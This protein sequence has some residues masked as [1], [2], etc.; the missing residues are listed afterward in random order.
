LLGDAWYDLGMTKICSR[1]IAIAALLGGSL[2]AAQ[3]VTEF[4]RPGDV[5]RFEIK[6]SGPDAVK[7]KAVSLQLNAKVGPPDDQS[8]FTTAFTSMKS[9]GPSAPNTFEAEV[10]VPENIASG[11]YVLYINAQAETGA[12]RYESGQQFQLPLLHVRNDRTFKAPQVTVV[13]RR[14]P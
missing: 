10:A 7:V 14:A 13:E 5:V 11:D 6:F 12:A 2:L 1:T 3:E 9:F 8:G 4:K